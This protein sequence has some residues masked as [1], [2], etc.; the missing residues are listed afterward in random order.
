M[1]CYLKLNYMP[2]L[3]IFWLA[4]CFCSLCLRCCSDS[5][6]CWFLLLLLHQVNNI[7]LWKFMFL[8]YRYNQ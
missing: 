8:L 6:V 3:E 4:S 2:T 7:Y 5:S 1:N